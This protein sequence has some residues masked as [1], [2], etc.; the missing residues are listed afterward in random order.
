MKL[1][2]FE[3]H[4]VKLNGKDNGVTKMQSGIQFDLM[5]KLNITKMD[6]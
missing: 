2:K 3:I 6:V 5:K 4:G 1:F